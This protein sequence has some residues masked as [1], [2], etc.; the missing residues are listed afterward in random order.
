MVQAP[1]SADRPLGR[2]IRM[3]LRAVPKN[4]SVPIL[5]GLNRGLRWRVGAGIHG[6]WLGTYERKK[7][8]YVAGF[9]RPGMTVF[10]VGAHAGYYTIA[11]ARLVGSKGRVLAFEPNSGNLAHLRHHLAVNR[12]TNVEVI[13]AAVSDRNGTARFAHSDDRY[14]G[15]LAEKGIEV[16]CVRLDGYTIP[17]LVK[18]DVEGAEGPALHGATEILGRRRTHFFI[19][20]HGVSDDQCFDL[21]RRNGYETRII[22]PGELHAWPRGVDSITAS[23]ARN[24]PSPARPSWS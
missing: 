17:D 20:L 9:V 23:S 24:S 4:L 11:F 14:Q 3:P 16:R 10:D 15:K 18:M 8:G 22:S 6:C 12:M 19:A 7:L 5:T 1:F 13:D 21:L 2:L